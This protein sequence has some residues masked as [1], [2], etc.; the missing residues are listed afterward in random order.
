MPPSKGRVARPE[1]R[2]AVRQLAMKG[3]SIREAA[4]ELG[5]TYVRAKN[6]Y[7]QLLNNGQMPTAVIR[8]RAATGRLSKATLDN[9]RVR[10]KIRF[11]SMI[12]LMQGLSMEQVNWLLDQ[13]PKGGSMS[14]ALRG[15]VVDA[16]NEEMEK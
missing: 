9:E 6:H 15:I 12:E 14:D 8:K 11:G 2:E 5:I 3:M 7:T 16:Y 10:R 4:I 1:E 13:V